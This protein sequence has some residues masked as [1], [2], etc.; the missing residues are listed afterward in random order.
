MPNPSFEN[1]TFCPSDA[2]E[3]GPNSKNG[4]TPNVVPWTM[5]NV[6]TPDYFNSCSNPSFVGVPSSLFGD[7][8]A[9][10]G[11]GYA[12]FVGVPN[13]MLPMPNQREYI[14]VQLDQPLVAGETYCVQFYWSLADASGF[15]MSEMGV[16][17]SNTAL[18]EA[19][20]VN[21]P[22]TPQLEQ[23][24]M[25]LDNKNC[26]ILFEEQY[27]ATGGEEF[28]TIGNFRDDAN[29]TQT[30]SAGGFSPAIYYF[31]DDVSV[32]AGTCSAVNA[33]NPVPN[34]I[35]I[36]VD[37]I[38]DTDCSQSTGAIDITVSGPAP[39][40]YIWS[41]SDTTEDISGLAAGT[42]TVTVTDEFAC[43]ML[44]DTFEVTTQTIF[45]T[46]TSSTAVTCGGANDGCVTAT[47]ASGSG[48]YSYIWSTGDITANVCG[49]SAG[50]YVVT[51]TDG[52]PALGI[53]VCVVVDSV[54]VLD[55]TPIVITEDLITDADCGLAN[56]AIDI[57]VTGGDGTY[58]YSWSNSE[59]T[60]DISGVLAGSYT[61]VVTDGNGCVD[62]LSFVVN[63]NNGP[64][65]TVVDT[66][67]EF[68]DQSN[69]T[70]D[71]SVTGNGTSYTFAWSNSDTNE[72]LIGLAEG[73]YTV[74]VTDNNGCTDIASVILENISGP[75]V[76]TNSLDNT[77]CG[78]DNGT[79][80][81]LAI[82]GSSP[83]NYLWSNSET[84]ANIQNL[85]AGTYSVTVTDSA[86]CTVTLTETIDPSTAV[87]VD[88]TIVDTIGCE[89][90]QTGTLAAGVTGGR[91][92]YSFDW[93]NT[94]VGDT[95]SGLD[96]GS[97]TVTVTD[98]DGCTDS[99]LVTLSALFVPTLDA[100][101]GN[102]GVQDT[103][104][105]SGTIID[106]FAGVNDETSNGVSYA[107]TINPSNGAVIDDATAWTSSS[108]FNTEGMYTL[109][110]TATSADDCESMD[111]ISV[112]V[113]SDIELPN[114]F[115][116]GSDNE[117]NRA[118]TPVGF[119]IDA[120]FIKKMMI[121]NRWGDAVYNLENDNTGTLSWDGTYQ[122]EEQPRGVYFYIIEY[123]LP[124]DSEIRNIR[125]EI[126]LIR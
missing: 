98:A 117:E 126:N 104:L 115:Y 81:V 60:P 105:Q 125:G 20:S 94:M 1:Y 45:S 92:S 95:I 46:T 31:I 33:A 76:S 112:F 67:N 83:Y 64:Q 97:F 123:Q 124:N 19:D 8:D 53:P 110:V 32:I 12:G 86:N 85:T 96:A 3:L 41:T 91:A 101:V 22:V 52:D 59:T 108:T 89:A 38:Q 63:N 65:V 26:W 50:T 5:P 84:T 54:V 18:N 15:A 47:P 23:T 119:G 30:P 78:N 36:T 62:S 55:A 77:T 79:I 82:G 40:N 27:V 61:V 49:L 56:G 37:N 24:G 48:N 25:P 99:S 116:P 122:G 16:Y 9:R 6:S 21:L 35:S 106:I 58:S 69:G 90:T 29:T 71:I 28:M 118:F 17:F 10:T 39:F 44:I 14:Q 73:T 42:Y 51:V 66:T 109:W 114:A 70:I 4:F 13:G 121:F 7:Q 100:Y 75:S 80:E 2:N 34:P 43:N 113:M 111:S 11:N 72:D 120:S 87:I 102:I 88:I 107:W 68:C 74:T 93:N 57:S 103:A